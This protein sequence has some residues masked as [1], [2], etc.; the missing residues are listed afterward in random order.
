MDIRDAL[1]LF[2]RRKWNSHMKDAF[3][4]SGGK[5]H[6]YHQR[7]DAETKR[8]LY[9]QILLNEPRLP[10]YFPKISY[11]SPGAFAFPASNIYYSLLGSV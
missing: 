5:K 1:L 11:L 6:S 4:V 8:W 7:W 3:L 9:K 10:S 2:E